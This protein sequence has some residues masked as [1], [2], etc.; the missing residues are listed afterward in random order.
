MCVRLLRSRHSLKELWSLLGRQLPCSPPPGPHRPSSPPWA[1]LPTGPRR[2]SGVRPCARSSA[3]GRAAAGF[4]Y[5]CRTRTAPR[6][7]GSPGPPWPVRERGRCRARLTAAAHLRGGR[8]RRDPGA[9]TGRQRPRR[10]RGGGPGVRDRHPAPR[11]RHRAR[12]LPRPGLRDESPG[13]RG[14]PR[15]PR[16]RRI[17]RDERVLVLPVGR[18]G[19]RGRPYGRCRAL[20]GLHRGRVRLDAGREPPLV[21]RA[22]RAYGAACSGRRRSAGTCC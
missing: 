1:S 8:G 22:R 15:R 5:D 18:R 16:R 12:D 6:R 13:R 4:V 11:R 9:R 2:A 14:P 3:S 19:R 21:G 20:R 17:R 10:T 7:C